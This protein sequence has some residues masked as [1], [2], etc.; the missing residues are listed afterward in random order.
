MFADWDAAI[1]ESRR[2]HRRRIELAAMRQRDVLLEDEPWYGELEEIEAQQA[3]LELA[4]GAYETLA[5]WQDSPPTSDVS[6][7]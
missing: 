5:T 2:L 1:L 3:I 4:L 7:R 6:S